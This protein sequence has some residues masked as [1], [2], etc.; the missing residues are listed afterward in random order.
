MKRICRKESFIYTVTKDLQS[1]CTRDILSS[2]GEDVGNSSVAKRERVTRTVGA[3]HVHHVAGVVNCRLRPGSISSS[4]A[5]RSPNSDER[6][7]A[8]DL[9]GFVKSLN[10]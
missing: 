1:E 5:S 2:M 9:K 3:R 10:S 7:A 4:L 6:R 8:V